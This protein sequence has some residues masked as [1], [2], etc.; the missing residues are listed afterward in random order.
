MSLTRQIIASHVKALEQSQERVDAAMATADG[1][2]A[3][4]EIPDFDSL[5]WMIGELQA[6]HTAA[7]L[8]ALT[9]IDEINKVLNPPKNRLT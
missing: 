7:K 3:Y 1:W 2:V 9:Q 6:A 5:Q 8:V 4:G